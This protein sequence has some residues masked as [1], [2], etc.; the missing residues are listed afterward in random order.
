[1]QLTDYREALWNF[2][3][4]EEEKM[5][6]L[7]HS[8]DE[9]ELYESIENRNFSGARS[10]V[11]VKLPVSKSLRGAKPKNYFQQQGRQP[12]QIGEARAFGDKLWRSLPED[13]KNFLRTSLSEASNSPLRLK[14]FSALPAVTDLPW[15][16]LTDGKGSF[17]TLFPNVRLTRSI[18]VRMSSPPL[19]VSPPLRVL[20]VLTNPKDERLLDAYAERQAVS[21]RLQQPDYELRFLDEPTLDALRREFNEYPPHILHYVGHAGISGGKGCIILH[22][23][24]NM[25][26][27]M[28]ASLLAQ[29]LPSTVRLVCL[30]T[31]FTAENYQIMGLSRFAHASAAL[32]LPTM[33]A[34][35]F[36]LDGQSVRT[37]WNAFYSELINERGDVNE[38]FYR[39]QEATAA[40]SVSDQADWT[41]FELVLRDGTG[42][43]LHLV[44]AEN[45]DAQR[46]ASELKA[47]IAVQIANSLAEQVRVLGD[48][49]PSEV[50]DLYETE[51]ARASDYTAEAASYFEAEAAGEK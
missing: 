45:D 3:F 48:D 27:W 16:Q 33:I 4:D 26:Y 28:N 36:P 46:Y 35:Q 25:T 10:G 50:R 29:M 23:P 30:S 5:F 13:T 43:A 47:Q 20:L 32:Q 40:A 11:P 38:A 8:R 9:T 18:P 21:Q 31:C 19:T 12:V 7:N 39:A 14:I 22:D 42:K 51:A 1:M 44:S 34:N 41:S 15:E 17:L 37:F 49:A 2:T 24:N 6:L